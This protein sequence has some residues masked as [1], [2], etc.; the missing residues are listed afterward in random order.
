MDISGTDDPENVYLRRYFLFRSKLFS[1]Y[2]HR[3]LRSD[4]DDYH[5][6]PFDFVGYIVE[7]EYREDMLELHP[8]YRW[9][10]TINK[11]KQ[12]TW[13]FRRAEDRHMVLLD[14]HF[15]PDEYKDAPLTI[16]FRGPYRREWGFFKEVGN[17]RHWVYWRD[18]LN[19]PESDVRE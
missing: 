10:E 16:I 14:K 4:K 6:H 18:Y 15:K 7:G 17:Q 3:F 11:R 12:G 2:I 9:I 5:D 19:V 13:A 8:K 1:I